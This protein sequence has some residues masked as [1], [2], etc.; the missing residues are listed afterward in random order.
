MNRVFV[1]LFCVIVFFLSSVSAA[2]FDC[3]KS[4]TRIE[5]SICSDQELSGL[6]TQMAKLYLVSKEKN[7]NQDLLL[8]TQRFW[9]Q[10]IRNQ[11]STIECL[12]ESYKIRINALYSGDYSQN[13]SSFKYVNTKNLRSNTYYADTKKYKY[14]RNWLIQNKVLENSRSTVAKYVKVPQNLKI[15]AQ[16][17]NAYAWYSSD[18]NSVVMCYSMVESISGEYWKKINTEE[19]KFVAGEQLIDSLNFILFHELGHTTF[20]RISVIGR[21][22]SAADSFS[23]YILLSEKTS[24]NNLVNAVW[25]VWTSF[26]TSGIPTETNPYDEHESHLQRLASFSCMLAG[27]DSSFS[28]ELIEHNMLTPDRNVRCASEW[29]K[30][31]RWMIENH[32]R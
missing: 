20:N 26:Q 10:N 16:D 8:Q 24:R 15:T 4:N 19:D 12:K 5:Q 23:A 30:T 3:S 22:E 6:D 11:C 27:K 25:G 31:K 17:C 29:D 7:E 9:I 1:I 18:S 28:N 21:E 32:N 14:I 2:S 13:L